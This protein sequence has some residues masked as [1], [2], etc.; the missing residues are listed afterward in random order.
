MFDKVREVF[1]FKVKNQ[2]PKKYWNGVS[3]LRAV[4]FKEGEEKIILS[5]YV[6]DMIVWL[7]ENCTNAGWINVNIVPKK[8]KTETRT[9]VAYLNERMTK[10]EQSKL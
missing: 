8:D 1:G 5:G 9:H 3:A 10:N 6:P 4:P 7:Q 2:V